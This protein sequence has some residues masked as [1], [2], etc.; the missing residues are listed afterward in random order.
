MEAGSIKLSQGAGSHEAKF[1]SAANPGDEFA[2]LVSE[3]RCLRNG[4]TTPKHGFYQYTAAYDS[5][6]RV[7]LEKGKSARVYFEFKEMQEGEHCL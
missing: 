4:G 3:R 1:L 5:K 7:E 6:H 2:L